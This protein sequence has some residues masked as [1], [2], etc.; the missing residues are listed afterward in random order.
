MAMNVI[1]TELAL[2]RR[3]VF[4]FKLSAAALLAFPIITFVASPV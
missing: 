1:I 2:E 3:A 4:P